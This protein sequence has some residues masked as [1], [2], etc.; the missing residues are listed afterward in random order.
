MILGNHLSSFQGEDRKGRKG[1][2][3]NREERKGNDRKEGRG[4]EG[5]AP[6]TKSRSLFWSW[7]CIS[8]SVLR[9]RRGLASA[10]SCPNLNIDMQRKS[11]WPCIST[12]SLLSTQRESPTRTNSLSSTSR[13]LCIRPMIW[14]RYHFSM[15]NCAFEVLTA[16]YGTPIKAKNREKE[17]NAVQCSA[18][19]CM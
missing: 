3:M 14:Q 6:W 13:K 8:L 12:S 17:K 11:S 7:L 5:K 19:Q 9:H 16:W 1:M 15:N 18:L 10:T 4:K 2:E